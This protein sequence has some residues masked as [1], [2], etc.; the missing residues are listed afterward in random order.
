MQLKPAQYIPFAIAV[1]VVALTCL[2]HSA[3]LS[4]TNRLEWITYD[5][6]ARFALQISS[7]RNATN[8]GF[9]S[10]DEN[11]IRLVRQGV[12]TNQDVR[13]LLGYHHG[14]YWPR[15]VYGRLVN[16]LAAQGA[17]TIAFDVLFGEAR[18]DHASVERVQD[19]RRVE[20][21]EYFAEECASAGNVLL[22]VNQDLMPP[23]IFATNALALADISTD[24]DPDG[25]LRRVKAFRDYTNWHT[26]FRQLE[27]D[28]Y[29]GV[30]MERARVE[31]DRIVLN[32]TPDPV[33]GE[34][35]DPIEFPLDAEGRFDLHDF[36]TN[37]PPG[38]ARMARPYT[39][40]R[41][42]H[43]GVM[44]AARALGLNLERAEVNLSEGLIRIPS[45]DGK[46]ISI[47][48]DTEGFFYVD[49]SMPPN[50]PD[51]FQEPMDRLLIQNALRL[52]GETNDLANTWRG[53]LA[54]VGSSALANDLTDRGAT[55]LFKDNLLVS[56]HWNV[57]NSILCGRFVHRLANWMELGLIILL[58][59]MAAW[60]TWSMR[61]SEFALVIVL[62]LI[63]SYLAAGAALYVQSRLWIPFVTPV[64]GAVLTQVGMLTWRVVFEQ[65]A[66]RRV[67]SIFAKMLSPKIVNELLA[68]ETLSLG[69][70][71][72]EISVFFADVRGF[73]SLTV[74]AQQETADYIRAH[75]LE[76]AAAEALY[77]EQ[78]RDTLSTVNTYL[79]VIARVITQSDGTLDKFIGDCVMA[80]WG[81]PTPNPRHA[82]SCV[83]AA[84]EA[85]RAVKRLNETRAV[86]NER[87]KAE[88]ERRLAAGERPLPELPLL[89]L[90]SGVN[91]GMATAGLMGSVEADS[92][93]YTVFGREVNLASRLEGASGYGRIFI[94][95]S[96]LKHLKRDD[97]QLAASCVPRDPVQL[98]GF[99]GPVSIYEVPWQ[100]LPEALEAPAR[101]Q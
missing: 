61:S 30:S 71:R 69:G 37:L 21:D 77:D 99:S 34:R 90:G 75:K 49:W 95:E 7:P 13:C 89:A 81:A 60:V 76:G 79:G 51:L 82:V 74:R 64:V 46:L 15:H 40:K 62:A 94:S 73:T 96:T 32:R 67:R 47:P 36:T 63:L 16:E 41:Y 50:H 54:V 22:A 57:A 6:R 65:A 29:L 10:I 92:L 35:F 14:L 101:T 42:W 39:C 20:S 72:R 33:T 78:A 85:Q 11:T 38:M 53:K 9:V 8:L 27:A 91:T 80:F 5:M 83:H 2:T 31:R 1:V 17:H 55:P 19:G 18:N 12:F 43:M 4:L 52:G 84:I 70:A 23:P 68:A 98:K 97:P 100:D 25:I 87:R 3:K 66:R 86:E 59:A 93:S 48:V 28:P 44:L 45:K 26:A 56:K 58:G 24:K 88:N